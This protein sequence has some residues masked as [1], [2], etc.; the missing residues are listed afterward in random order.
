MAEEDWGYLTLN[1]KQ[2]SF[3]TALQG[4]MVT[5]KVYAIQAAAISA[6]NQGR[7]YRV[8]FEA[9]ANPAVNDFEC[10]MLRKDGPAYK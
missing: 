8:E 9:N 6:A 2:Q 3:V 5:H 4:L 10:S 1:D 7:C